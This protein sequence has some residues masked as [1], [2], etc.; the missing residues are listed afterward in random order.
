MM[1]NRSF[2]FIATGIA[3]MTL[4]GISLTA[5]D[6]EADIASQNLS[7]IADN[8]GVMRR[9]VFYNVHTGQTFLEV[10]GLCSLGNNDTSGRMS[11]TCKVGPDTYKKHYLGLS[12]QVTFF[13]E[14]L[15]PAQVGVYHYKVTFMPSQ[16]IPNI[17]AK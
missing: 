15:E 10:E 1:I 14:Q 8:F 17:D 3:L 2:Y 7:Q 16:V 12:N 5:C 4:V 11:V 9:V 6:N 13:A